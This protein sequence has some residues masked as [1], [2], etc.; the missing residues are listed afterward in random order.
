MAGG[1]LRGVVDRL[2]R[3]L[4]PEPAREVADAE[5][6]RRWLERKDQAAFELL[7]CRNAP[8]MLGVCRRLLGDEHEARDAVQAAFL[9]LAKKARSIRRREALGAWRYRVA[10]RTA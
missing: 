5:L 9:V 6:L 4:G 8:M 2:R 7:V 1:H 3:A 10:Y